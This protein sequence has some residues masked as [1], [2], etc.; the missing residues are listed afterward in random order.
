ML[1]QEP[2]T[3]RL[4]A[5]YRQ[6]AA[7]PHGNHHPLMEKRFPAIRIDRPVR[8]F[9]RPGNVGDIPMMTVPLPRFTRI[10]ADWFVG[11]PNG[12]PPTGHD[13][14]GE[15]M[16]NVLDDFWLVTAEIFSWTSIELNSI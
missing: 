14:T 8:K 15:L 2:V 5:E 6:A 7:V 12:D 4:L 1:R 9:P 16:S 10:A 3:V 13:D 11:R